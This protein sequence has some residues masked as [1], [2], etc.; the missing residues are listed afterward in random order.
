MK[1]KQA[2]K[3]SAAKKA[4]AR[5]PTSKRPCRKPDHRTRG[6]VKQALTLVAGITIG[7]AISMLTI[8]WTLLIG[9]MV[10]VLTKTGDTASKILL[11][12]TFGFAASVFKALNSYAEGHGLTWPVFAA[13]AGAAVILSSMSGMTALGFGLP[14]TVT[15]GVAFFSAVLGFQGITLMLERV[16]RR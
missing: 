10:G 12:S 3:K 9:F 11:H 2:S 13:E 16:L 15:L 1:K 6:L 5:K 4:P 14:L 7:G 8:D